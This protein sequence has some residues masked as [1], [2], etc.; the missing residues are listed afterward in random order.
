MTKLFVDKSRI[1]GRGVF[2]K[3]PVSKGAAISRIKGEICRKNNQSPED[4]LANPDWVGIGKHLWIDPVPP[5]KFINHSCDPSAGIK[6]KVT[7][8]ALRDLAA[9]EEVTLDYSTIEGDP[10]WMMSCACGSGRCRKIIRSI[11]FLPPERFEAYT[12]FI[13]SYFKKLYTK[14]HPVLAK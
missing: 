9:G 7:L 1:H 12:P 3:G 10:N 8:I 11:G 6:G 5:Y 2:I 4:S 13:P 14:L